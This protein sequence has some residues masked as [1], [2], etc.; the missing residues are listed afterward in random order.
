MA[1]YTTQPDTASRLTNL[2]KRKAPTQLVDTVQV[3]LRENQSWIQR[4]AAI[5][6]ELLKT[7]PQIDM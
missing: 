2:V 5:V 3:K 6:S 1:E 4:N 7:P